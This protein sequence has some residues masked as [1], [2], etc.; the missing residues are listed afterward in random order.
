MNEIFQLTSLLKKLQNK[1][2]TEFYGS[3]LVC[4]INLDGGTQVYAYLPRTRLHAKLFYFDSQEELTNLCKQDFNF[5]D[6][7][8]KK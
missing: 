8:L 1:Y 4:K 2:P 6:L 7:F 5:E 3:Y